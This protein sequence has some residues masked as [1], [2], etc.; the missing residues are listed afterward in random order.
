[1]SYAE[2]VMDFDDDLGIQA[3]GA[4]YAIALV[5]AAAGVIISIVAL[6]Q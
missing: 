6:F 5:T 2:A 3:T 4:L 1:M